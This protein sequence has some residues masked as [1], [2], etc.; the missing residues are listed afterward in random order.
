MDGKCERMSLL[1]AHV[2]QYWASRPS[3]QCAATVPQAPEEGAQAQAEKE[4]VRMHVCICANAKRSS[5]GVSWMNTDLPLPRA[6][7]EDIKRHIRPRT[8]GCCKQ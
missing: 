6:Q 5:D 2:P 1:C 4:P 8:R 3:G 7:E